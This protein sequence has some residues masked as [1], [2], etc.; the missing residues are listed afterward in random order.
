MPRKVIKAAYIRRVALWLPEISRY[1]YI[2]GLPTD[3]DL[4]QPSLA[5]VHNLRSQAKK[6][7]KA[8]DLLLPRLMRGGGRLESERRASTRWK[9]RD[10]WPSHMIHV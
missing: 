10:P 7:R 5:Q 8:R 1:D 3:R 6:A 9:A 4:G 2:A